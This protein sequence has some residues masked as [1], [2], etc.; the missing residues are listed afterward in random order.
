MF[1]NLKNMGKLN[2]NKSLSFMKIIFNHFKVLTFSYFKFLNIFKNF[3]G[4]IL[5]ITFYFLFKNNNITKNLF[6]FKS[7]KF[8]FLKKFLTIKKKK[9]LIIKLILKIFFIK[10]II[11]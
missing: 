2:V 10:L 11:I 3:F 1:F 8:I 7:L 6:Y 4:K 5:F 9:F